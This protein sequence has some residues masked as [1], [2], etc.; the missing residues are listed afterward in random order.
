VTTP[1]QPAPPGAYQIGG[2][3]FRYGQDYKESGVRALWEVPVPSLEGALDLMR[4]VLLELPLAALQSFLSMIP[5]A[6]DADFLDPI[7]AVGKIMDS[8][9]ESIT[10]G[11][12]G[13]VEGIIDAI[14]NAANGIAPELGAIAETV[15]NAILNLFGIGTGAQN[16]ANNAMRE[17]NTLKGVLYSGDGANY[18][19]NLVYTS[20]AYLP[21][22][23]VKY[24][25]GSG[26]GTSGPN[27]SSALAWKVSGG[28]ARTCC[29][30]NPD[31]HITTGKFGAAMLMENVGDNINGPLDYLGA[32]NSSGNGIAMAIGRN[33]AGFVTVTA[34]IPGTL[35]S[36]ASYTQ[37]A[38]DSWEIYYGA[39]AYP[40]GCTVRLNTSFTAYNNTDTGITLDDDI[41]LYVGQSVVN[42]V[43]TQ[44]VPARI[45]SYTFFE[46]SL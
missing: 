3:Q 43:F 2:G 21:S 12:Q 29:Y 45:G 22:P 1:N 36:P 20:S 32:V 26:A 28:G 16:T 10:V 9:G 8:L 31:F 34:G 25:A 30:K 13:L 42:F 6:E 15:G 44:A 19:D 18:V 40:R 24:E 41:Y 39:G 17:I 37:A 7:L 35:S 38:G 23:Y 4:K 5:G 11:L 14:V 27:G 46:S 33:Q